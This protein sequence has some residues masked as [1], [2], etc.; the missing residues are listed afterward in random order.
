MMQ[1]SFTMQ[2]GSI[3]KYRNILIFGVFSCPFCRI[4]IWKDAYFFPKKSF[5]QNF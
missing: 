2:M 1:L 5:F 4:G 3:G